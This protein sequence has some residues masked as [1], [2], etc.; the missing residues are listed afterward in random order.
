M[1]YLPAY[2]FDPIQFYRM[3]ENNVIVD[4]KIRLDLLLILAKKLVSDASQIMTRALD[5]IRFD[6]SWFDTSDPTISYATECYMVAL[7]SVLSDSPPLSNVSDGT[8]LRILPLVGWPKDKVELL[9][10]GQPL[11]SLVETSANPLFTATFQ[12]HQY[13]SWLSPDAVKT[14]LFDFQAVESLL[15]NPNDEMLRSVSEHVVPWTIPRQ[16]PR[17]LIADAYAEIR[18]RLE[19][20]ESRGHALFMPYP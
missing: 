13:G 9:R 16:Q 12:R 19:A 20:A 7:T 5:N 3:L 8:L 1:K 11:R 2:S 15:R 14:L 4:D 17:T 10:E 18:K 6:E